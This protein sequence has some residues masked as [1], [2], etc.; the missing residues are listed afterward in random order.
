MAK[1]PDDSVDFG[2]SIL[3][4]QKSYFVILLVLAKIAEKS[5]KIMHTVP[6]FVQPELHWKNAH[7][8]NGEI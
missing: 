6:Y 7:V 3:P 4:I 1:L 2:Q 5:F 8:E